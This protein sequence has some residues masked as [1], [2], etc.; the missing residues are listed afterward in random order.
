MTQGS[1]PRARTCRRSRARS[2]IAVVMVLVLVSAVSAAGPDAGAQVAEGDG[3]ISGTVT[4]PDGDPVEG[5]TVTA[6][7]YLSAE[8][9]ANGEYLIESLPS[10]NFSVQFT[11]P[12]GSDLAP[13]LYDD[14]YT[15]PTPIRVTDGELTPGIDAQLAVG[16]EISGTITDPDGDPLEGAEVRVEAW[17]G[18]WG[19]TWLTA[20][21]ASD[22]SYTVKGLPPGWFYLY[23]LPP[24]E[25][26]LVPEY[27]D[28][29]HDYNL[30]DL[31]EVGL[32]GTMGG[33]DVQLDLGGSISGTV[34]D[35]DGD[36]V[37]GALVGA[38][39]FSCCTW[40]ETVTGVDGTYEVTGL[41]PGEY[42]VEFWPPEIFAGLFLDEYYDN[43]HDWEAADAVAVTSG[44]ETSGIDA[45]FDLGGTISGSVTGLDGGPFQGAWVEATPEGYDYPVGT[46]VTDPSGEYTVYGL[47]PGDYEV[48]FPSGYGTQWY[49][50]VYHQEDRSLV[51]LPPG[52]D[53]AGID[54]TFDEIV[55]GQGLVD[56]R[57]LV[58]FHCVAGD[59]GTFYFELTELDTSDGT[60]QVSL[61]FGDSSAPALLTEEGDQAE[62]TY[63]WD[64]GLST[65]PAREIALELSDGVVVT[66]TDT[67]T[68]TPGWT[69]CMPPPAL[70][71]DVGWGHPFYAEIGWLVDMGITDGFP[72][73]SFRPT[74]DIARQAVAAWLWKMAGEPAPSGPPSFSDVGPGHPFAAAIAWLEE[75]DITDGF[76]DGSFRPTMKITRQAVAAWLWKMAGEPAPSGPPSFS[77]VGPGHPFATAIAWL[78]EQDITDGFPDGSFRPSNNLTRQGLAAWLFRFAEVWP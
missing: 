50:G 17:S 12:P 61:D 13:E 56:N 32:G 19:E 14:S 40:E 44:A 51:P 1:G 21:S 23:V 5:A 29:E 2:R 63:T 34:T 43:Q 11:P 16:G 36:P 67:L 53:V 42:R 59:P 27:Y 35:P 22:G 78:E 54:A 6:A 37:Q 31:L 10:G 55:I 73:G 74:T 25:T 9:D 28:D 71:T 3:S 66:G 58:S 75:Q 39:T 30:A 26:P 24:A 20:V 72:D 48:A 46:A 38:S 33:V 60:S 52:G 7:W 4:D 8:T 64:G 68:V 41:P 77:D 18:G 69:T 70:F 76:P 47:P 57:S 65:P 62:H 49:E 45:Q 15:V